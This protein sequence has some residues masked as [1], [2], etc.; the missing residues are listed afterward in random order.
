MIEKRIGIFYF[1]G[2][3]DNGQEVKIM[4]SINYSEYTYSIKPVDG[5]NDD[6][7][8]I[9]GAKNSYKWLTIINLIK[10]AIQYG[11]KEIMEAKN[12]L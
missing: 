8:F 6:F 11:N 3:A 1:K 4:L 5:D 2:R 9:N 10:E 12:E 7:V